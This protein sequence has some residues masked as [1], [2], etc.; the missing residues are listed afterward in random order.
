MHVSRERTRRLV[1]VLTQLMDER[2]LQVVILTHRVDE[3]AGLG[4]TVVDVEGLRV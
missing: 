3:Y 1:D 4:G 2:P